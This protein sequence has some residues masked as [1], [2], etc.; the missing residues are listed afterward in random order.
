MEIAKYRCQMMISSDYYGP[1]DMPCCGIH[2][3]TINPELIVEC[4]NGEGILQQFLLCKECKE[5]VVS[6]N[7]KYTDRTIKYRAF[8]PEHLINGVNCFKI[9]QANLKFSVWFAGIIQTTETDD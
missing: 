6:W 7:K 9:R 8:Y 2:G 5:Y 1:P 4:L 3:Q